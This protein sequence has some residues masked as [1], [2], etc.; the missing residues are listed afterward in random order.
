MYVHRGSKATLTFLLSTLPYSRQTFCIPHQHF[1]CP[2][3]SLMRG[4]ELASFCS[5]VGAPGSCLAGWM[6]SFGAVTAAAPCQ[7]CWLRCVQ[8]SAA[9]PTQQWLFVPPV[10]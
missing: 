3:V 6:Q 9:P 8:C 10:F 4:L 5:M 1:F 7:P 2:V